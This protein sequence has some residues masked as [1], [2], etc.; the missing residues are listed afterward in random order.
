MDDQSMVVACL[1]ILCTTAVMTSFLFTVRA[2][3]MRRLDRG[4]DTLA[5]EIR[6]LRA[7]VQ[8]LRQQNNEL[9]LGFDSSLDH[10][11]RRLG[12]LEARHE[13]PQESSTL[14]GR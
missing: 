9:L 12:R 10:T 14:I 5:E 3:L 6:G 2:A 4:G 8:A 7:E 13:L 1:G 11:N